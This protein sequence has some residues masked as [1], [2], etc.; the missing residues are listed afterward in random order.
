[1]ITQTKP[2][3]LFKANPSLEDLEASLRKERKKLEEMVFFSPEERHLTISKIR[4]LR[5]SID[6]LKGYM[7]HFQ[8]N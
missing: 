5:S 8:N 2:Q 6:M 7:H 4:M 1:M 3:Q